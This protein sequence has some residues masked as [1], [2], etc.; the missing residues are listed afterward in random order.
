MK[1]SDYAQFGDAEFSW[2][3]TGVRDG[4]ENQE[5]IVDIDSTGNL[6]D[7][8]S[9]SKK[10]IAMDEKVKRLAEKQMAVFNKLEQK[11]K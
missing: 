2:Q 10:R 4:F 3:V 8:K 7:K 11:K 9:S 6:I 1:Q 5:V